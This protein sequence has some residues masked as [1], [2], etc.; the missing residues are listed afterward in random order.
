ME[1]LIRGTLQERLA[2]EVAA[3]VNK[4]HGGKSKSAK[5]GTAC[6]TTTQSTQTDTD[7]LPA[8]VP[9]TLEQLN[10]ELNLLQAELRS[11]DESLATAHN[12][13]TELRAAHDSVLR[14]ALDAELVQA[15]NIKLSEQLSQARSDAK[16]EQQL[17]T[18]VAQELEGVS[19]ELKQLQAQHACLIAQA[20]LLQASE[21]THNHDLQSMTQRAEAAQNHASLLEASKLATA[22]Q[23]DQLQ[24]RSSLL[25][26]TQEEL[27]TLIRAATL[28]AKGADAELVRIT[29]TDGSL[30]SAAKELIECMQ[31]QAEE[32]EAEAVKVATQLQEAQAAHALQVEQLRYGSTELALSCLCA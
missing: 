2:S 5:G 26:Q 6:A 12:L 9:S 4:K 7:T 13:N 28:H 30:V 20:E 21:A 19:L 29:T 32:A 11:K 25:E 8:D 27:E 3:V 15:E 18:Q 23:L 1:L 17:C 31:H 10:A 14:R 24:T 16:A 22:Q